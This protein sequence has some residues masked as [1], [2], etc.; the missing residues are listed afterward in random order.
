MLSF[1][2][3]VKCLNV[4][5][6]VYSDFKANISRLRDA[7]VAVAATDAASLVER[8]NKK[9]S[10]LVQLSLSEPQHT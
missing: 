3:R 9:R 8:R 7:A 1:T 6:D 5:K 4:E 2:F 10:N